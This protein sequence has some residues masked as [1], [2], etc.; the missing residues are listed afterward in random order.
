[1]RNYCITDNCSDNS[2]K[3]PSFGFWLGN[4]NFYLLS[5]LHSLLQQLCL[6]QYIIEAKAIY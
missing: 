4:N 2:L 3:Y 6:S 5:S 1:M